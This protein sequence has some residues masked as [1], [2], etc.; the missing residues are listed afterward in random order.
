MVAVVVEVDLM[1]V[2]QVDQVAALR[3]IVVDYTAELL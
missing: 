2:D 3:I 1:V